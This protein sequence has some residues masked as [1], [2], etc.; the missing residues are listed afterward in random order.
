MDEA[1]NPFLIPGVK[2]HTTPTSRFPISSVQL[3]RW[4]PGHWVPFGAVQSAK[5]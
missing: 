4:H 1:D 2:V 3:Q 5:P